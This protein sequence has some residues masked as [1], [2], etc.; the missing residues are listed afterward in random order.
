MRALQTVLKRMSCC[1]VAA[2]KKRRN[3]NM[4]V[5]WGEGKGG[6][7][8]W[9]EGRWE[10][11]WRSNQATYMHIHRVQLVR[12]FNTLTGSMYVQTCTHSQSPLSTW[13]VSLLCAVC[14]YVCTY[15]TEPYTTHVCIL[16]TTTPSL[17][18]PTSLPPHTSGWQYQVAASP[19]LALSSSRKVSLVTQEVLRRSD[20]L[21]T[22]VR[23]PKGHSMSIRTWNQK[24]KESDYTWIGLIGYVLYV[25]M[26]KLCCTKV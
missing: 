2:L 14:V 23:V 17:L 10:W 7:V 18:P 3:G 21:P 5:R 13:F 15:M 4:K 25:C 24:E 20:R 1:R 26:C 12:H 22:M 9:G 11:G 16:C 19:S 8:R 6:E